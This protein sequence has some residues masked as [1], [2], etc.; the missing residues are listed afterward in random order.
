MGD[1][2]VDDTVLDDQ[3][4]LDAFTSAVKSTLIELV[5]DGHMDYAKGSIA[6]FGYYRNDSSI[7]EIYE[8]QL[9]PYVQV[10]FDLKSLDNMI[11]K[12][13]IND[14]ENQHR[15]NVAI[16]NKLEGTPFDDL[17]YVDVHLVEANCY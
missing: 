11:T 13:Y 15:I 4:L 9:V 2:F 8:A 16:E 5:P 10:K 17:D 6:D 7:N 1:E 14:E 12:S 3:A